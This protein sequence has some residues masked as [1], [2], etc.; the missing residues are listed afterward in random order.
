ML[1]ATANE[2]DNTQG[3]CCGN[4]RVTLVSVDSIVHANC[5]V[6]H[7]NQLKEM[8]SKESGC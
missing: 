7:H 5:F 4:Q 1:I 6:Q 3:V 2:P 8:A